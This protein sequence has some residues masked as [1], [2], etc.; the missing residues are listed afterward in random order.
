[1][2]C[3]VAIALDETWRNALGRVV[4]AQDR[5]VRDV[6]WCTPDQLHITLKFLGTV[7]PERLARVGEVL[8]AAS[9]EGTPFSLRRGPIGAF[10][11]RGYPRVLWCGVE[12]PEGHCA[13]WVRRAEPLFEDIGFA[14]EQRPFHAH[15]TLARSRSPAGARRLQQAAQAIALPGLPALQVDEVVLF[16]SRLRPQGAQYSVVERFALGRR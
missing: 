9:R 8:R 2:R 5:R 15:I 14:H 10:P 16:E 1:M 11:S 3:F 4:A 13:A 7:E 12:D 6:R